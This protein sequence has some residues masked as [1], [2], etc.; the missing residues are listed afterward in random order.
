MVIYT[1]YFGKVK[2]IK[3]DISSEN[4]ILISI[5]R[6]TPDDIEL[7]K[8]NNLSPN[9]GLFN[10]YKKGLIDEKEFIK[11]YLL[12][13]NSGLMRDWIDNLASRL[14]CTKKDVFFICYEKPDDFC[15]RHIFS[16][17]MNKKYGLK[18]KEY[19]V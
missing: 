1:T 5:A 16:K 9:A 17:F 4:R 11:Q 3:K 19:G 7:V 15:H 18:I 10:G 12:Q 13:I 6:K 2:Q 8:S 14:I